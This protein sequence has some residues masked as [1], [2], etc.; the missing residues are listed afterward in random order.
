MNVIIYHAWVCQLTRCSMSDCHVTFFEEADWSVQL[1]FL[2]EHDTFDPSVT[3]RDQDEPT[4]SR[5]L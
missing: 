3:Q 4:I 5:L 2:Q 1:L